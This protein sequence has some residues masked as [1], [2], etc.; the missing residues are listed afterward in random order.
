VRGGLDRGSGERRAVLPELE[1]RIANGE[2]ARAVPGNTTLSVLV[3]NRKLSSRELKQL[4]RAVHGS[5]ARAIQPFHSVQDGD[6]LWC[7]TTNEVDDPR[8]D[9]TALGV[10]G[11]ELA[12]D[13]VL[14]SFDP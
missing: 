9:V 4:G 6:A 10:L 8:L 14:S 5:M 7:A 13:A 2:P 3:S 1:R 11:A 12:W